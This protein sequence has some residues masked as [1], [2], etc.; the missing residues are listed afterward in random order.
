LLPENQQNRRYVIREIER[1]NVSGKR[2]NEP[3]ANTLVVG[4]ATERDVLRTRIQSRSEQ[5]FENGMVE[6]AKILGEKYGWDSEAMTGNIYKLVKQF[7]NNEFDEAELR[8]RFFYADWQLAKR[9]LTWLKRNQFI[10]WAELDE[11][12]EYIKKQLSLPTESE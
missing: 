1:Q 5:L 3:I 11:A 9:Q 8:Q 4:I 7:L 2:L 10:H 12:Y 6:E